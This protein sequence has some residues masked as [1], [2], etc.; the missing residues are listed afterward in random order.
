VKVVDA[1]ALTTSSSR[2]F[3]LPSLTQYRDWDLFVT[4][5]LDKECRIGFSDGSSGP[6]HV[7]TESGEVSN[8][9]RVKPI[10]E[11]IIKLMVP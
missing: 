3:T 10:V 8:Y 4:N 9:N 5:T 6:M 2:Y 1:V 7:I 11:Q